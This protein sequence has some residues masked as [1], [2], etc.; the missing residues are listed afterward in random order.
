MWAE[1]VGQL[2]LSQRFDLFVL[3]A[4]QQISDL[5]YICT[6]GLTAPTNYMLTKKHTN[7]L[8]SVRSE[9]S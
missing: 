6:K 8:F 7:T 9:V 3:P 4:G 1:A 2:S 5:A